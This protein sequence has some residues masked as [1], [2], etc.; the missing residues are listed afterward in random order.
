MNLEREDSKTHYTL[1]TYFELLLLCLVP[2]S[3]LWLQ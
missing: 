3:F 1:N 2:Y